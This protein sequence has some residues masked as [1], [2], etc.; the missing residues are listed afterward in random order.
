MTKSD[1]LVVKSEQHISSLWTEI[2][3][4]A[5]YINGNSQFRVAS[6]AK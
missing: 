3:P 4:T 6:A 2:G 1:F 5:P